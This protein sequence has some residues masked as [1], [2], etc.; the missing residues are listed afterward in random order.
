MTSGRTGWFVSVDGPSGIGK[1]TTVKALHRELEDRGLP[2][3]LT[4]EPTHSELGQFTREHANHIHGRALA[5]LVAATRY[6]HI[7]QVIAPALR[8]GELLISDR[9][10]PSTLVL[11]QLDGVPLQFLLDINQDAVMPDLA[12]IL[13]ARP[14]LI[15]ERLHAR[16]V[17]HRFHLDPA[18]PAREVELYAEAAAYFAGRGVTV[19]F[20]DT[21][22]ATPSDV[23]RTIADAIPPRPIASI[24]SPT[25]ATP[26]ES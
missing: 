6:E 14:G 16:G 1:S 12:V 8:A 7:D 9:Y 17:T 24:A 3:R 5:C 11:Q 21:S 10:L 23:V 18:A 20:L 19:L 4:V 2:A 13:T 22:D 26:Q 15:A 25:T